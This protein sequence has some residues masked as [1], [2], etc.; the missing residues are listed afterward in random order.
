MLR[1]SSQFGK[2]LCSCLQSTCLPSGILVSFSLHVIYFRRHSFLSSKRWRF[3]N[4]TQ[5]KRNIGVWHPGGIF[6]RSTLAF[7][8]FCVLPTFL[9]LSFISIQIFLIIVFLLLLLFFI[10]SSSSS[11]SSASS[12]SSSSSC[13]LH[14]PPPRLL[15]FLTSSSP[16]FPCPTSPRSPIVLFFPKPLCLDFC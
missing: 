14:P 7:L 16:I 6:V 1:I 10:S 9:L 15:P 3:S 11:S 13:L 12:S 5:I 8:T 2:W 4:T